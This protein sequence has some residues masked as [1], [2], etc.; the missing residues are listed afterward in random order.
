MRAKVRACESPGVADKTAPA[1]WARYGVWSVLLPRAC[2][3]NRLL[4]AAREKLVTGWKLILASSLVIT[5]LFGDRACKRRPDVSQD[6]TQ[7]VIVLLLATCYMCAG[8]TLLPRSNCH[9]Q[10]CVHARAALEVLED[11]GLP[12]WSMS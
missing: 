1:D 2:L 12:P 11:D 7:C 3:A 9:L 4:A 8:N 10:T 5:F 6:S